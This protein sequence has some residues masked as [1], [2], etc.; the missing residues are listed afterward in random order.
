MAEATMPKQVMVRDGRVI[1][2]QARQRVPARRSN[3]G[4]PAARRKSRLGRLLAGISAGAAALMLA[5]SP[6][7]VRAQ[8]VIGTPTIQFGIETV[9]RD[10]VSKTDTVFVTAPEALLDW[11]STSATG[12]FL[13]QGST[14]QFTRDGQPFT[15]LNRVTSSSF[16]GPLSISGTVQSE[17]AGK[18]WFY[19]P[20]GWVV[21]ATGVFNV[22]SL[23]LTSLPITV[24]PATDTVSRL[25]G[26]KGEIRFGKAGD[27]ASSVS[28][29]SGAQINANLATSSYVALVAPKVSQGGTVTVN[30]SVAYVGAEAATLTINNGLF[31]II[32]DSGSDDAVGIL[33]TGTTTGPAGTANDPNHR[34]HI[35]AVPKN[36]AMTAVVSGS[37]GYTAANT[38][39]SESDGSI[40]LSAGYTLRS[41]NFASTDVVGQN[42]S[43]TMSDLTTGNA[44]VV[45]A[46]DGITVDA[47]ASDVTF[48]GTANL[49]ARGNVGISADNGHTLTAAQGL[50]VL[51]SNGARSGNI[52]LS[53]VGGSTVLVS[54]DLTL[55]S[56]AEGAIRTDPDNGDALQSGS[57]GDDA[58]SGNVS[59]TVND[60]RITA[61]TT[62]LR[63]SAIS[64]VGEL[65]SGDST[66]GNVSI[67]IVQLGGS[68]SNR[69]ATFDRLTVAS[70]AETGY[71]SFSQTPV[72]GGNS[73]SGNVSLAV[74]GGAFA[75][76]SGIA[77][78]SNASTNEGLDAAPQTAGAGSV[79]IAFAN[80]AGTW[81]TGYISGANYGS[82][83]NGG[84]VNLGDVSL[85][86]DNVDSA[87]SDS[88]GYIYLNSS[89]YGDLGA[90]NTV[91]LSLA[92][93]TQL[94]TYGSGV[95]LYS[96]SY[97]A[98]V[99]Q[100][101]SNIAITLDASSLHTGQLQASSSAR[102]FDD[103]VNSFSGNV[104]FSAV[105]GSMLDAD[106]AVSLRSDALG[107][108]GANG[109]SG[110]AGDVSLTLAE[111]TLATYD[112]SMRSTGIA[113]RRTTGTGRTGK[114]TGGDVSFSQSGA[115]SSFSAT[116][117]SIDNIGQ[118]GSSGEGD[119]NGFVAQAGD[120]A[121][122]V[123]G[124]TSFNVG[125]GT[126]TADSL[127]LSAEGEGGNSFNVAGLA[128]GKGGAGIAGSASLA[129]SGGNVTVGTVDIAASG[130]GGDGARNSSSLG[131]VGGQG[132]AGRGGSATASI[133][134]GAL[135]TDGITIQANGNQSVDLGNGNVS[136]FGN[137]GFSTEPGGTA[138]AGGAGTGGTALLTINGGR[139]EGAGRS[140]LPLAVTVNA[141]GEGGA[142]G[143]ARPFS[144]AAGNSGAG[145]RGT[146]GSASIRFLSGTFDAAD[147]R[148]DAA[149]LGGLSGNAAY[150]PFAIPQSGGAGG[151]GTGGSALFETGTTFDRLN[152]HDDSRLL[153]ISA[154][155][156][157][158]DGE[159]AA[160][161]GAGGNGTGGSV[162]VLATG[163]SAD[164]VAATISANG[165][166]G[167]GAGSANDADG[168]G[169]GNG[170]GGTLLVRAKGDGS[171]LALSDYSLSARGTGGQGGNGGNGNL[172]LDAAGNGGA[173]GSGT[174]GTLSFAASD[175]GALT[176]AS[177]SGAT[178][179]AAGGTGGNGGLAGNADANE[180]TSTG[181]GGAGGAGRGGAISGLAATGGEVSFGFAAFDAI[182]RGGA[183]GGLFDTDSSGPFKASV[184]GTGG[185]GAGGSISLVATG[186]GSRLG[187]SSLTANALGYGGDG[188]DGTGYNFGTGTGAAG[189]A[190]GR[191]TGGEIL[192]SA[193]DSGAL[194]IAT[195][196]GSAALTAS[197]FGGRGGRGAAG[198]STTGGNGGIGGNGGEAD[199]GSVTIA[200]NTL[201]TVT[202]R[203]GGTT[204][205][206]ASGS[207]GFGGRGGFGGNN[208]APDGLGG[209]GG[210]T[211]TSAPGVGGTV[212][213]SATGGALTLGNLD[214]LARGMTNV[215]L[216]VAGPGSGPG[217]PGVQG[218]RSYAVPFGGDVAFASANDESGN[219]G[220]ILIGTATVTVTSAIAFPSF[221]FPGVAGFVSLAST[222][223][224]PTGALHFAGL[225]V[226]GTGSAVEGSGI[227]INV[228]TGPIEVDTDLVLHAAGPVSI[229]TNGLGGVVVGNL[230]EISS[231]SAIGISGTDGGQLDAASIDLRT[232]G[233][234]DIASVSCPDPTCAP[235]HASGSLRAE[236]NQTFNLGGP[237]FIAGLGSVD[238]YA[239]GNITGESRSGFFSNGNVQVRGGGDVTV[240][241]ATGADV[242]VEA[243]AVVDGSTFYYPATLT[244]GEVEGGG[245]FTAS[246]NMNF[247]SGGGIA[248]TDGNLF[249]AGGAM[250]FLSGNDI[251]V[252]ANNHLAANLD[253][254]FDP[255]TM[256]FNA[257]G[258]QVNYTLEP[259]D[260]AALS[261]GSGT[262]VAANAGSISLLGAAVDARQ[263]SFSGASLQVDVSRLLAVGDPRLNDGG[264][265]YPDC[266]EG[267]ICIGSIEVSGLVAIGQGTRPLDAR[268]TGD[269]SG[270][271]ILITAAQSVTVGAPD[272]PGG[273][274]ATGD[275]RVTSLQGGVALLG[276]SVVRGGRRGAF[277]HGQ[278]ERY[279][280]HRGNVGR[281][282]ADVRR[283]HRRRF[284]HSGP[285]T[286]DGGLGRGHH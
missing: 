144:G 99:T 221:A 135:L 16:G 189:S 232:F 169:G 98:L 235:V 193:A 231:D 90:V 39:Q 187:V 41:G 265:L 4:L 31:D 252:G 209:N 118:G 105:S 186:E 188:V 270:Q 157:G 100:R 275:V 163:G 32:V 243:G 18:V 171:S 217:G 102:S 96:D 250:R 111:S 131:I 190:G 49:Y 224:L 8:A 33:H 69:S 158:R 94:E 132:G 272:V 174:G 123:G 210:D 73:A 177:T 78:Y 266:L 218:E 153:K 74:N 10:A 40:I 67:S 24:D 278:P 86:Y 241:N 211:G 251:A 38:A 127:T 119:R 205:I 199:G 226:D 107:G 34:I 249:D 162:T 62:T 142:G 219:A 46:S 213:L 170:T 214:I 201:G 51:S 246:S 233:S 202:I 53:A 253:D 103:G 63:S 139:V 121:D 117:A 143:Y 254:G 230:A 259:A 274:I 268:V 1:A 114:G 23:V 284:D 17:S 282:R 29:V 133:T 79:S 182:G 128:P 2:T 72:S 30:G 258:L 198:R 81:Q 130:T 242:S 138:G 247:T 58:I 239:G 36:Q 6:A 166:G 263:S 164:L 28:V 161:G 225:S 261:F 173:G 108:S 134:G 83:G 110:T 178:L 87:T 159:I 227:T 20:G 180:G 257:G 228:A 206:A 44:L 82:A 95:S 50:G 66:S 27:P 175:L 11:T 269:V 70:Q 271:S 113:G 262:T 165:T 54:G 196:N 60:G 216:A 76:G 276:G 238:V 223:S 88:N 237:A 84:A 280:Q 21:G 245:R 48:N 248:V 12:D 285:R 13:P 45:A 168:A 75:V 151:S 176:V 59:L 204:A 260:I 129:I 3:V 140:S 281:R 160:R 124:A 77:L 240:R 92:N 93:G 64:G 55:E 197:A 222:S 25:L 255:Q 195:A 146:G 9:S 115:D 19:N 42:A 215:E 7:A 152:S 181:T 267:A 156:T 22:G 5:I 126:F 145:G 89:A 236:A 244:L 194:S 184:G 279:G 179:I 208:T 52:T 137:G 136:Y 125:G 185:T 43:V 264:R 61:G 167:A 15:V 172:Q 283:G 220:S 273:L 154:N 97:G 85:S 155:G 183:G 68:A 212:S 229:A 101:S 120:G 57:T 106:F 47:T 286:D 37:L 112:F 14:L 150:T 207:G 234:I 109:G 56:I 116:F 191:A 71:F 149:G 200:A 35:V 91:S 147:I 122:G 104:A 148:I 26:D 80:S 203:P 256:S 141:L 192:F 277:G 65:S